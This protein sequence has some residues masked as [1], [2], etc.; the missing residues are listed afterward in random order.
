MPKPY[1][2]EL[3][4]LKEQLHDMLQKEWITPSDGPWPSPVLFVKKKNSKLR[5][6]V[7]YRML[8]SVTQSDRYTIPRIDDNLDR[9]AGC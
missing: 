6:C 5:L 4:E 7:Y 1:P 9:L 8:N 2:F 3:E